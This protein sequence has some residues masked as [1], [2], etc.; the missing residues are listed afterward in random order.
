MKN[1]IS[2]IFLTFLIIFSL[3]VTS[4]AKP[5]V[6]GGMGEA[7]AHLV[8]LGI[9]EKGLDE[10]APFTRARFASAIYGICKD[11]LNV[12]SGAAFSDVN[13]ENPHFDAISFC[14]S[15]GYMNG[16]DGTFRPD[17]AISSMEAVTVIVRLLSY[18]SYAEV[19][20]GY[21]TGYYIAANNL[22]ILKGTKITQGAGFLS[23]K[24]AAT[25]IYN[26]L[27]CPAN[28]ISGTGDDFISYEENNV[29]SAE[30]FMGLE[31]AE[32]KMMSNG[33]ID[34]SG[35]G[36]FGDVISVA[37]KTLTLTA[38]MANTAK[39]LVGQTVSVFY[40]E[41]DTAASV[42]ALDKNSTLT[43]YG[44]EVEKCTS[45][46]IDYYEGETIKHAKLENDVIYFLNGSALLDF[47]SAELSKSDYEDIY[48]V[49]NNGNGA[50]EYVFINRYSPFP[51]Y[52]WGSDDVISSLTGDRVI[53]LE[54]E[55]NVAVFD[56]NG[57]KLD[58][59]RVK[60]GMVLSLMEGENFLYAIAYDGRVSG[61]LLE[62]EPNG[63]KINSLN[64]KVR[65]NTEKFLK[66]LDVGD[67]VDLYFD[68]AGRLCY[69]Q[70]GTSS[71][72]RENYGYLMDAAVKDGIDKK[73]QLKVFTNKR[74]MK[75][76][77]LAKQFTVNGVWYE[78][79][80]QIAV[81]DC[82][83][84]G[85]SIINDL[86]LYEL[87][88]SGEII[89]VE[90]SVDKL[91]DSED[92]FLKTFEKKKFS[93]TTAGLAMI[94]NTNNAE[95]LDPD[96]RIF[97]IPENSAEIDA[98]DVKFLY[99]LTASGTFIM[100]T[101]H[102]SKYSAFC[103]AA[104][105]YGNLAP[106][107]TGNSMAVVVDVAK[108]MDDMGEEI[109]R[110]TYFDKTKEYTA[111]AKSEKTKEEVSKLKSGDTIRLQVDKDGFIGSLRKVYDFATDSL[112]ADCNTTITSSSSLS[113]S[114]YTESND[115]MFCTM[116]YVVYADGKIMRIADEF[117][118][119]N[120][121]DIF[122]MKSFTLSNA[123]VMNVDMTPSG[124]KVSA[125]VS[126]DINVGDKIVMMSRSGKAYHVAIYK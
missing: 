3:Q 67:D 54:E 64:I 49:D 30:T 12:N 15:M 47:E 10:D 102:F 91:S 44:D 82:F 111:Y 25:L 126:G 4:F 71:Q 17:D 86:I 88:K 112:T 79:A 18:E 14:S 13:K 98:Y 23:V 75:V 72:A 56:R 114:T 69:A 90:F 110:L 65:N 35:D 11:V 87:N 55:K 32:G 123:K 36:V 39:F 94:S 46:S 63:L 122:L 41:N 103:D 6:N 96:T 34:I 101:Y 70:Y 121:S 5:L 40:N 66:D 120:S 51:V 100:S 73:L 43:I 53:N 81:P 60:K 21:P 26:T 85:G 80:A 28:K 42:C 48:F 99:E 20:G 8:N 31:Y 16:H 62:K 106:I 58:G 33:I 2:S 92:G 22:G 95:F 84:T 76:F 83:K 107:H 9:A 116:G 89:S 29:I 97:V 37:G 19:Y 78:R 93:L 77:D 59:D 7:Y 119:V 117:G 124:A 45:S 27:R 115:S 1:K 50:Y 108:G 24:T 61:E 113:A 74:E 118:S 125:G 57:A 104:V 38:D 68:Y 109:Y 105:I 52:A